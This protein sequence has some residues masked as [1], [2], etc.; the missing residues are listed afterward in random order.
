LSPGELTL[1]T[2]LWLALAG[3]LVG[4]AKTAIAGVGSVA[5]VIFAAV[6]PAR[7]ST[8][9]ILPLLVCGDLVAVV[10][11]RR[12]A[13]W[14][15]LLRLLPGV[16][17][18]LLL[19]VWFLDINESSNWFAGLSCTKTAGR[20][21]LKYR[22]RYFSDGTA[23]NARFDP[24]AEAS[25]A[26]A[27]MS[28]SPDQAIED[29][30]RIGRTLTQHARGELIEVLRGDRTE[31]RFILRN[32]FDSRNRQTNDYVNRELEN[33]KELLLQTIIRKTEAINQAQIS[34]EPIFT[35]DPS[36]HG[37]QDFEALTQEVLRHA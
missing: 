4:V 8:G 2:W 32:A 6:L 9:A 31:E 7:E 34:G 19:G 26:V 23:R 24:N 20:L 10:H 36:G 28:K 16:L 21:Q 37:A 29:M 22:V 1:T 3:V 15:I 18:G 5:V 25:W 12:H 13:D 14:G 30:R 17:P 35:Y 33:V 11:Y 27:E